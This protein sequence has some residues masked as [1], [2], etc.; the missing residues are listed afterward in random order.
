[1]ETV[2]PS[3]FDRHEVKGEII[4]DQGQRIVFVEFP[5]SGGLYQFTFQLAEALAAGGDD[6]HLI[7]GRAPELTSTPTGP[8]VHAV[9]PTWHPGDPARPPGRATRLLRRGTRAVR[10]LVAWLIL[11]PRL[12]ALR[13]DVVM[14]SAWRF[15]IDA[16]FVVLLDRVLP[17]TRQAI[18]AH[19]PGP[20]VRHD[21]AHAKSGAVLDRL[22]AAAWDRMDVGFVLGPT[23]RDAV[24]RRWRPRAEIVVIPHGD[25]RS[26]LRDEVL[27][28]VDEADPVAL[29][30]GTWTA[31]KG[32]DALLEAFG[33]VR[34]RMPTAR[35]VL[36]GAVSS[37]VD[38]DAIAAQAAEVG[39]VDV[40]PGYV[41]A[42]QVQNLLGQARLVVLPY[43]RASQS[44]VAH[45]AFTFGRPVVATDVG[46]IATV[47]R[48]GSTGFLVPPDRTDLLAD[49][50]LQLLEDPGSARRLGDAG[51]ELLEA[52]SW[53]A[54]AQQVRRGLDLA[55]APCTR[56]EK[57]CDPARPAVGG[58]VVGRG[59]RTG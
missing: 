40:R 13:P 39:G 28:D 11:V 27:T 21:T 41:P 22:L 18:I 30:F 12:R 42:G 3:V 48:D 24:L 38:V 20:S 54:V 5:P 10:L 36:A 15:G 7:T 31:Y 55:G 9:L 8:R 33:L 2:N 6:V 58:T 52:S 49:R 4:I 53:D 25:E 1:V 47:V 34:R 14:W 51:R 19:E 46:D 35:L 56:S 43:R 32:I 17:S 23:A 50:I 57:D 37:D 45:L 16:A 44:G 59:R 29:F 26:L